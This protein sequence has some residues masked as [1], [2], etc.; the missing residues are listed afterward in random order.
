M[1]KVCG[2]PCCEDDLANSTNYEERL[3]EKKKRNKDLKNRKFTGPE[4]LYNQPLIP[5]MIKS[6]DQIVLVQ[7]N[8]PSPNISKKHL[9]GIGL[10]DP[11]PMAQVPRINSQ[12]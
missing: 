9:P 8:A 4:G 3:E 6:S 7:N 10:Y 1:G 5:D 2:R 11:I 12:G